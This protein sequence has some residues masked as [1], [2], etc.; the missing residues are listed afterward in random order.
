GRASLIHVDD[1]A[2]LLLALVSGGDLV[3]R[4][5]FDPD[6]GKPGGWS[7]QELA[8]AIGAAMDRR[9]WAPGLPPYLLTWA[10]RGDKLLRGAK[11]RLT[12]DRVGYLTHPDWAVSEDAR[13]PAELWSPQVPT[14]DGLRATADWYRSNGWL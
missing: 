2:R 14:P 11:A 10:A 6:D 3:S 12:F 5:C 9:V 7:H 8:Q 13:V 1:L 4:Q